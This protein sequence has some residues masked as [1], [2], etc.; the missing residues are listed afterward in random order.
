MSD[1]KSPKERSNTQS[2]ASNMRALLP[3]QCKQCAQPYAGRQWWSV[4]IASPQLA[5]AFWLKHLAYGP[6]GPL[7]LFR[8]YSE[9]KS[10][11]EWRVI[12]K[13]NPL[14]SQRK[15]SER[16]LLKIVAKPTMCSI[17]VPFGP[18]LH[19]MRLKL[20]IWNFWAA[21]GPQCAEMIQNGTKTNP[22]EH[23]GGWAGNGP[24]RYRNHPKLNIWA[25]NGTPG[26]GWRI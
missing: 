26:L 6:V 4:H 22:L 17:A 10:H 9:W 2:Y 11:F 13:G 12:T 5:L 14:Q 7:G 15:P 20:P 1:C 19:Q 18:K 24:K 23:L 3:K 8:S 25:L 16:K 21:L